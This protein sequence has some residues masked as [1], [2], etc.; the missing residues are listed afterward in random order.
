MKIAFIFS[1][2]GSQYVGMGKSF[3][4]KFSCCKKVFEDA[5]E[6]LDF[7]LTKICFKENKLLDQTE[8]TQ[9][10]ILTTSIAILK[11]LEEKDIKPDY[12]AGLS[13]GEYSA[14]VASKAFDFK[15]TV[16]LVKK[17]GKFMTEAV[18][19]GVGAMTAII[20]ISAKDIEKICKDVSKENQ[21]VM[22]ANYNSPIQ[23]VISGHVEAIKIVEKLLKEKNKKFVRL[24]VS[25]P[26]H[27]PLLE[28]ASQKL[29]EE[30][31]KLE[32]HSINTPI[33]SNVDAEIIENEP[34]KIIESLTKQVMSPVL[35]QQSVNKL[36]SLGVDTFI[37]I[38]PGKVLSGFVKKINKDVSIFNVEDMA[39]LEKT[40]KGIGLEC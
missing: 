29:K 34:K 20:N 15:E 6:A 36:I 7:D 24:N 40:C 31:Q 38:G 26:F 25:G 14:L 18:E 3:F 12:L 4:K 19:K 1:G 8:F 9:P 22:I 16:K 33:I 13:L 2:Q 5:N 17:R 37:E 27:T 39:S 32:I 21:E 28:L 30:L 23:T 35:W 11:L 10:A